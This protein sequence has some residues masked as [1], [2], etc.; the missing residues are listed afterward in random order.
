MG[1]SSNTWENEKNGT[2]TFGLISVDFFVFNKNESKT[3]SKPRDKGYKEK[4]FVIFPG[5]KYK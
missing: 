5:N 3:A 2:A 4:S 1:F